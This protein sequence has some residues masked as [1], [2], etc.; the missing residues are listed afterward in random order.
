MKKTIQVLKQQLEIIERKEHL[1][2]L[3]VYNTRHKYICQRILHTFERDDHVSEAVDVRNTALL[4][5][6]FAE[7]VTAKAAAV[8]SFHYLPKI[9]RA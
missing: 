6:T 4:R 5:K 1:I 2:N 9:V 7:I 8:T 3:D